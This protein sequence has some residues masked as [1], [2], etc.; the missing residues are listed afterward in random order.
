L[1]IRKAGE[2]P[3]G[4][5]VVKTGVKDTH[6]F[7]SDV[8]RHYAEGRELALRA[9]YQYD[10][11]QSSAYLVSHVF[12]KNNRRHGGNTLPYLGKRV[13]RGL[14]V[15]EASP[16]LPGLSTWPATRRARLTFGRSCVRLGVARGHTFF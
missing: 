14:G 9:D 16:A 1:G 13:R 2:C 15:G 5:I 8:F 7:E 6:H 12:A 10:R 3:R 4:V 11:P